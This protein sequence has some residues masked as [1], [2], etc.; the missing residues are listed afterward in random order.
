MGLYSCLEQVR[1]MIAILNYLTAQKVVVLEEEFFC[2]LVHRF[3]R[4]SA[5]ESPLIL[6]QVASL[7]QHLSNLRLNHVHLDYIVGDPLICF[8]R[9]TIIFDFLLLLQNFISL[10]RVPDRQVLFLI[11]H[12]GSSVRLHE[13]PQPSSAI[14]LRRRRR[15]YSVW[16]APRLLLYRL[17][18]I[19]LQRIRQ[20]A[21]LG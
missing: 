6:Q 2:W 9:L 12:A 15:N 19:D 16:N 20:R 17:M 21:N 5:S 14:Q 4:F 10:S 13:R 1:I 18:S 8:S 11:F 3:R 7:R